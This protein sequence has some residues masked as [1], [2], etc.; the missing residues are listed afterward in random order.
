MTV[1]MRAYYMTRIDEVIV[2]LA[3]L[4]KLKFTSEESSRQP[5]EVPLIETL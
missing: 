1:T 2:I 4:A 3:L 5:Q